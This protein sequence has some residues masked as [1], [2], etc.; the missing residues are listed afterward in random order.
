MKDLSMK[1]LVLV[2]FAILVVGYGLGESVTAR[3]DE[4]ST[5][6]RISE[7]Q[8]KVINHYTHLVQKVRDHR[9]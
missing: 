3:F 7:A 9:Y 5:R 6:A 4:V 1:T 2:G 8:S